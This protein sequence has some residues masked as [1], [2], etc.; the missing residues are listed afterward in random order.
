LVAWSMAEGVKRVKAKAA[1]SRVQGL[2]IFPLRDTVRGVTRAERG[3]GFTPGSRS[4]GERIRSD[5]DA[6]SGSHERVMGC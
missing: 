6:D 2:G 1:R 4:A 3:R 5:L